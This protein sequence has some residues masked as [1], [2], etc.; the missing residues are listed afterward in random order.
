VKIMRQMKF[1]VDYTETK[2]IGHVPTDEIVANGYE[3][4]FSH[5]RN[6]YPE[7][8][9]H[10]SNRPDSIFNRQDWMQIYQPLNAG[11]ESWHI[12]SRGRGHFVAYSNTFKIDATHDHNRID[13]TSDNVASLRFYLNDQMVDFSRPVTV[14][15]NKKGVFE[16]MVTPS[17]DEM[18]KDQ[19]FVGRG[20]RYFT[21]IIDVD[22]GPKPAT[23]PSTKRS[24]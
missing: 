19:L 18:L 5:V 15:V 23:Q 16:A 14:N 7:R 17:V 2:K 6:L 8:I 21:G 24:P 1:D 13:A 22:L 9:T 10:Q 20:W 12:V 3:K 4:M 11:D